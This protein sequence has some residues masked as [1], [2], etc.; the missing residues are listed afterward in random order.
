MFNIK[1][2]LL[3]SLHF[4]LISL[5]TIIFYFMIIINTAFIFIF[6]PYSLMINFLSYQ[7][8]YQ[9]I[10]NISIKKS[11]RDTRSIPY[12]ERGFFIALKLEIGHPILYFCNDIQLGLSLC[13]SLSQKKDD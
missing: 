7:L 12:F 1:S 11:R 9:Q 13:N 10:Q 8:T 6:S 4:F 5:K 3:D 2:K